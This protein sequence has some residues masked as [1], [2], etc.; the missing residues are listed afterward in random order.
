MNFTFAKYEHSTDKYIFLNHC[1]IL[2]THT[3]ICILSSHQRLFVHLSPLYEIHAGS[4]WCSSKNH[5]SWRAND[6]FCELNVFFHNSAITEPFYYIHIQCFV[7]LL[8]NVHFIEI[9]ILKIMFS[10]CN[11]SM[12]CLY[13]T[14]AI[15]P[16]YYLLFI[17]SKYLY[18]MLKKNT[19]KFNICKIIGLHHLITYQSCIEN[20]LSLHVQEPT[21]STTL[22][23]EHFFTL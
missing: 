23:G 14:P 2:K 21:L 9:E 10:S 8:S 7:W 18:L 17:F 11:F 13:L 12:L 3:Q 6:C 19:L 22:M 4:N 15:K 16:F 5:C 1:Q 20:T